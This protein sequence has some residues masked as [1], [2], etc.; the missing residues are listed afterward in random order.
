MVISLILLFITCMS[1]S[2][3]ED[4]MKANDKLLLYVAFGIVMIFIAG[5]R[6]VGSTPDTEAYAMYFD[7]N[8]E[9]AL[10]LHEPTFRFFIN[11]LQS[12]SLGVNALFFVYAIISIPI[13]LALFWKVSKV[14]LL[15]LTIYISYYYMMHEM[16]QIRAGVAAGL[17]LW[18]IYFYVKKQKLWTL[19][20]I[21]LGTLF[22]FSAAAGLVIFLLRD[23]LPNWERIVLYA[24][25]PV[26]MLVYFSHYDISMLLPDVFGLE[27][28]MKYR[29]ANEMGTEDDLAG[30]M[31]ES[32][33]LIWMNIVLYYASIYYHDFLKE[34]FKY[35][36]I[37][38]KVQAV[39]FCFLFFV[40]SFS[41]VVG[42]RMNDY[43][44]IASI[45]LWTASIYAFYPKLLSKLLSNAI[46][47]IR[48]AASM[49]AYALA[50][51]WM[52]K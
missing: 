35:T 10:I 47:T 4:Q 29:E 7:T 27:R 1:L 34:R 15:T 39:G 25:V 48:F 43:F 20:F 37:A 36:T 44:S 23:K 33:P 45:L 11:A 18:A 22:H 31:F 24:L 6:A 12:S 42:N 8:S 41:K 2:F 30:W 17:F 13:H 51:L 46:S 14:P 26:G 9:L 38:I 49:M 16:V 3:Y 50:L 32:H 52:N 40:N 28:L 21:L 19:A 5:M